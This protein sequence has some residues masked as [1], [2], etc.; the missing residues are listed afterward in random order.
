VQRIAAPSELAGLS[1]V[2]YVF[3]YLGFA[4]PVVLAHLTGLA[5]YPTLL[6]ALAVLAAISLVVVRTQAP[7]RR[8]MTVTPVPPNG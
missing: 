2:F 3:T 6:L 8:V 5:G 7:R 1:A 4:I